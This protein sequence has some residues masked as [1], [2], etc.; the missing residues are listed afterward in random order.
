MK[1]GATTT[2]YD[3]DITAENTIKHYEEIWGY[4]NFFVTFLN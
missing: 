3:H 4:R 1:K 2:N